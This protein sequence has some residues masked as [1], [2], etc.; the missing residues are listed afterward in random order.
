MEVR[1]AGLTIK[2]R[3]AQSRRGLSFQVA[4][5][6]ADVIRPQ[7]SAATGMVSASTAVAD[8]PI[9]QKASAKVASRDEVWRRRKWRRLAW[10]RNQSWIDV[11]DPAAAMTPQ[12]VIA[13]CHG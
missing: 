9:E 3:P 2:S 7:I 4:A 1:Q 11:A 8:H 13:A 6:I 12:A 10:T 5:N